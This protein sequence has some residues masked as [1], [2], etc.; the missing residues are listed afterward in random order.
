MSR[1]AFH[2]ANFYRLAD[3]P[4]REILQHVADV[5]SMRGRGLADVLG[6]GSE[7]DRRSGLSGELGQGKAKKI[8][9][10][11]EDVLSGA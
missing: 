8:L 2:L 5:S 11:L 4:S 7:G 9:A 1:S 3:A 6:V 10:W